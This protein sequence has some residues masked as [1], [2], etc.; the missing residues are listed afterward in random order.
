MSPGAPASANV[1]FPGVGRFFY[2]P[3]VYGPWPVKDGIMTEQARRGQRAIE[4][5]REG[6]AALAPMSGVTDVG[7]R[8]LAQRF[9][10]SLV[11][12]EMVACRSFAHGHAEA[13]TRAEG[14]GVDVH[15][16]Q[17]AGCEAYW[18]GEGARAAEAAGAHIID[19]NMGCPARSVTGGQSGSA[20]MRDLDHALALIVRTVAAVKIPVTLKMRLGWDDAA[21]NAP[22]LARR[23]GD[24]GVAMVTVHG[25][26]RQQ[27]YKG[28]AD[29]RAVADVRAAISLPL[30]VNGDINTIGDAR[31]ALAQSGADAVM[32][33]RAALGQPW[34]VGEIAAGLTGETRPELSLAEKTAAMCEHYDCMIGL[35]GTDVGV[36]HARKHLAAFADHAGAPA[37]LRRALTSAHEPQEVLRLLAAIPEQDVRETAA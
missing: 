10:A 33:G 22:E 14:A 16:V 18:M 2:L 7:F 36:R 5:L 32:V 4:K 23:A 6:G 1:Y 30:V 3:G 29:W 19:I 27:F 11:V 21:R 35:Y 17:L 24:A 37:A 9:G 26:T 20:L 13:A 28:H 12:S 34:L 31:N 25:R 15:V 8:R